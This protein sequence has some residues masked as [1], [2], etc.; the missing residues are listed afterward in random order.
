MQLL[1]WLAISLV[2]NQL[3]VKWLN[4]KHYHTQPQ[5]HIGGGG[6]GGGRE[7]GREGGAAT[8]K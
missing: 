8:H 7:G 6:G 4:T 5:S 1:Q 3:L 2:C